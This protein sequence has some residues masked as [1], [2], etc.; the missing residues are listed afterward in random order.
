VVEEFKTSKLKS[1]PYFAEICKFVILCYDKNGLVKYTDNAKE[2]KKQ[3][4]EMVFQGNVDK[5][6]EGDLMDLREGTEREVMALVMGYLKYQD[7][8]KFANLMAYEKIFWENIEALNEKTEGDDEKKAKSIN[9]K[10]KIRE[11]NEMLQ[12][13]IEELR[14]YIYPLDEIGELS[15]FNKMGSDYGTG[16]ILERYARVKAEALGEN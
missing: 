1:H 10:S 9:L 13:K 4:I 12:E 2:R 8:M 7:N 14:K 5:D 15:L 16:N 11:E 6:L 3:A